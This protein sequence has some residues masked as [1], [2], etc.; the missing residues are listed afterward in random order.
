VSDSAAFS[1]VIPAY[2]YGYC[3]ERALR[4]VVNQDYP[5]FQVLVI[6]D[7]STD[8][9]TEVLQALKARGA[10]QPIYL[11]PQRLVIFVLNR[12]HVAC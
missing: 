6:N 9:T 11:L 2:N 12:S 4:P 7:S 10:T 1:V 5:L 8:N 3:I